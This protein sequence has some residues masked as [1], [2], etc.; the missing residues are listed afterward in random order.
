M[1]IDHRGKKVGTTISAGI[2][3]CVPNFNTSSDYIISCADQA[4]YIAKKGGK[5]RVAVHIRQ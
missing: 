5:N 3:C 2:M 4:L 1:T